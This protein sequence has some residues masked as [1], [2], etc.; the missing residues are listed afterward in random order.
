[1]SNPL[2]SAAKIGNPCCACRHQRLS[3]RED[4]LTPTF[5]A[6]NC[7][8]RLTSKAATAAATDTPRKRSA[9]SSHCFF[10]FNKLLNLHYT[11]QDTYS[12]TMRP[13]FFEPK[14]DIFQGYTTTLH[15]SL[16]CSS[17]H[18]V[19]V[20]VGN[21]DGGAHHAYSPVHVPRPV[22]P[23]LVLWKPQRGRGLLW[24]C[25]C[26]VQRRGWKIKAPAVTP[27]PV[28]W[29]RLHKRAARSGGER[30][31][32]KCWRGW[33]PTG[34]HLRGGRNDCTPGEASTL[35][36]DEFVNPSC[37]PLRRSCGLACVENGGKQP[38]KLSEVDLQFFFTC[39][40]AL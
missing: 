12:Y 14:P 5:L 26:G 38:K 29:P 30:G 35:A 37:G 40:M 27:R 21:V 17:T 4:I 9:S 11:L 33:C 32:Q 39:K 1:M 19:A 8:C 20:A 10:T 15:C 2:P 34:W 25:R 36:E 13:P 23:P 22:A 24:P 16:P 3:L 6:P 28:R 7:V 18:L 31:G